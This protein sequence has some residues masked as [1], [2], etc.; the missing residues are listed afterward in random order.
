MWPSFSSEDEQSPSSQADEGTSPL[1][2]PRCHGHSSVKVRTHKN[3]E[4][5]SCVFLR[6]L[7]L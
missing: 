2:C 6:P 7:L 3:T 4:S 5:D 1:A